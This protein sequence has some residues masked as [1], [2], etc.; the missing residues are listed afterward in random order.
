MPQ[1]FLKHLSHGR[2]WNFSISN[3]F[4]LKFK[5]SILTHLPPSFSFHARD[6]KLQNPPSN[7]E[8][9]SWPALSGRSS[10]QRGNCEKIEHQVQIG[11]EIATDT[12]D[13]GSAVAQKRWR[14]PNS[15]GIWCIEGCELE[16][17]S[18]EGGW[19][20]MQAALKSSLCLHF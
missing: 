11:F 15:A 17:P 1:K 19:A 16:L 7:H 2:I 9:N 12:V 20:G 18:F 14:I 6:P 10:S 8:T 13:L 3:I 5:I 4:L